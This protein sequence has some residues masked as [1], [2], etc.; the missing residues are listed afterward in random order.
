MTF[1][2][3]PVVPYQDDMQGGL[4]QVLKV[5][6]YSLA[7]W[8][9]QVI[10]N[11]PS[12][13][14]GWLVAQGWQITGITYDSTKVPPVPYYSMTR[15]SLQNWMILQGLLEEWT[16][17]WNEAASYNTFRYNDIVWAWDA[18]MVSTQNHFEAQI[19]QQNSHVVLFL[20][21]LDTYMDEVDALIDANQSQIVTDA[22]AAEAA[23][24]AAEA[25]LSELESNAV[26]AITNIRSLLTDQDG[27]LLA[28]LRD[29]SNKLSELDENYTDHVAI[30]EPLLASL[31]ATLA[32]FIS[33]AGTLLTTILTD[34]TTLESEIDLLL[35]NDAA[36]LTTHAGDF[37]A[38]LA[39]LESDYELHASMSRQFLIDLG[40]TETA[41]IAE[42]FV[43]SL[44]TQVQQ[45]ID[46][47]LYSSAVMTDVTARNARDHNEEI[48]ALNDRLMREKLDNQHRLY[49]QQ[50][51]MR[52][53]TM[54]GKNL[55][56]GLRLELSK[57]HAAQIT[58]LYG[59]LQDVRNRTLS[60]K[61]N[62]LNVQQ[63]VTQFTINVRDGLLAVVN[64]IVEKLAA[65]IDREYTAKQ[66]VS[67]VAMTEEAQMLG[68]TQDAL[69]GLIAGKDRYA[70]ALMQLSSTLAEHR[71]R[72]II[73]KMN[74][75][76]A[77]L[78]GQQTQHESNMKLMAYQLDE[79][80]KLLIGIYGFVER[81]EDVGPKFDDLAK[82]CTSLGDAGGGW[83]TP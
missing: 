72:A 19:E 43:S 56:Y 45:L 20:G 37:N 58:G 6:P 32:T 69:K 1:P 46:R 54:D 38:V 26:L 36:T 53:A 82:I 76:N 40:L 67:R 77:R 18:M 65:G 41:R 8:T 71:H 30:V 2:I 31:E 28:F 5:N 10:T 50:V 34:Y 16:T 48:V 49:G 81:R 64:G 52:G 13:S 14:V 12:D 7:W 21:N 63:A 24:V 44:S 17:A 68:M 66:D 11:I 4:Q 23:L 83:I 9:T 27:N 61:Q 25:R 74:E 79:R 55:I 15:Q 29:F 60:T 51:T 3:A 57:Y 33:D 39:L 22:A 59:L 47:G 70:T 75:F 73:E 35:A 78:V 42:K 80:N 62:I